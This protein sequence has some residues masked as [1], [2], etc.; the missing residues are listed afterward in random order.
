M[1][2]NEHFASDSHVAQSALGKLTPSF[3]PSTE[4]RWHTAFSSDNCQELAKA[5][6]SLEVQQ[7]WRVLRT[8]TSSG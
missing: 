4:G 5:K 2:S 3:L 7:K 6:N 1:V 8:G